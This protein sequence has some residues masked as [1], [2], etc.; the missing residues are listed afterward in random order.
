MAS[1]QQKQPWTLQGGAT[2]YSRAEAQRFARE[3]VESESYRTTVQDRAAKGTLPP[4]IEAMLWYYAYGKPLEQ[5]SLTVQSEDLSSL[6]LE[7]LQQRAKTLSDKLQE[8]EDVASA[9]PADIVKGPW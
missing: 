9:I 1:P 7:E 6:S 5:L 8:A 2:V 4:A 3:I